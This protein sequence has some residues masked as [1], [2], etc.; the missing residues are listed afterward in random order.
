M[1]NTVTKGNTR[2]EALRTLRGW[3]GERGGETTSD[4][5]VGSQ[6]TELGLDDD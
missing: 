1:G 6:S 2:G 5:G 3:H 4:G